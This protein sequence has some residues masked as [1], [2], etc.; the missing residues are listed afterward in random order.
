[1]EVERGGRPRGPLPGGQLPAAHHPPERRTWPGPLWRGCESRARRRTWCPRRTAPR[2]G[3]GA[4]TAD[5]FVSSTVDRRAVRVA[6]RLQRP[7]PLREALRQPLRQQAVRLHLRKV[8]R[9]R[10]QDAPGLGHHAVLKAQDRVMDGTV[11]AVAQQPPG[12]D[13]VPHR[14]I[15]AFTLSL[16][17]CSSPCHAA[18]IRAAQC[19]PSGR[20]PG[21][22]SRPQQPSTAARRPR[23]EHRPP[24]TG[25]AGGRQRTKNQRGQLGAPGVSITPGATRLSRLVGCAL[26]LSASSRCGSRRTQSLHAARK[27]LP[28][29]HHVVQLAGA[30]TA[31]A[32]DTQTQAA[33]AGALLAYRTG[34]DQDVF[35]TNQITS[36]G[37]VPLSRRPGHGNDLE[38]RSRAAQ[39][40]HHRTSR[41]PPR[42]QARSHGGGLGA[43]NSSALSGRRRGR[44]GGGRHRR[45]LGGL[46]E[47]AAALAPTAGEV[48]GAMA[49]TAGVGAA[50]TALD[51]P[52][53]DLVLR[54]IRSLKRCVEA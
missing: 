32:Q 53:F 16:A 43:A 37:G 26:S 24:G 10:V 51:R 35:T 6:Q 33:I 50:A 46:A 42:R 45:A 9:R 3:L 28:H 34:P 41:R 1:M 31:S 13:E 15:I 17:M 12:V 18:S 44:Q 7:Q 8:A 54:R 21:P 4:Q 40:L 23:A 2:L 20:R 5:G 29:R 25:W 47:G 52:A 27:G 38:H 49:A 36:A 48:A 19:G 22:A 11:G 39:L 30:G 14:P